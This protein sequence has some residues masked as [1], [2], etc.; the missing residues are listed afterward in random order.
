MKVKHEAQV[1]MIPIDQITVVNG[2]GRGRSKFKR[3]VANISHIGLKKPITVARRNADDGSVRYDLVC[4]QGRLEAF[5]A[6]GQSEVPAMVVDANK[7]DLF[8]M[9]LAENCARR[10]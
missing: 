3:I 5:V 2:R 7:D 4:G 8:L 10:L 9:S 1:Q 6:L